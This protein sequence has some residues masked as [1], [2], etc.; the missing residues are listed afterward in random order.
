MWGS[1]GS[2]PASG[3]A[4]APE[5]E[6]AGIEVGLDRLPPQRRRVGLPCAVPG[7]NPPGREL[8]RELEGVPVALLGDRPRRS[9]GVSGDGEVEVGDL[10]AER[11]VADRPAGDPGGL[12]VRQRPSRDRDRPRR[13]ETIAEA[14]HAN[15]LGTRAEI[16]QVIS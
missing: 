15:T 9:G 13:A 8:G 16:P 7:D 10:E 1:I 4:T 12:A 6:V 2:P 11:R 14:A 5:R 3:T